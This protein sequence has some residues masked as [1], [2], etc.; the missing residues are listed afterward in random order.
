ME[1]TEKNLKTY[2]FSV[3]GMHCK[4]CILLTEGELQEHPKVVSA[5]SDLGE[6][7]VTVQGDFGLMS[8]ETLVSELNQLL[9]KHGY[10]LSI[11]QTQEKRNFSD[12]RLALPLAF[13]LIGLLI[14]LQK[15]GLVELL[16]TTQ[17]I[18]YGTAFLI[19]IVASL[20]SCLAIVGGLAL[21]VSASF[22]KGGDVVKPQLLFHA[23]RLIAFFFLGGMIGAF[24]S[25]FI[26]GT[27]GTFILSVFTGVIMLLLGLNLLD[28]FSWTKSVQLGMPKRIGEFVYRLKRVNHR[29]TPFLL[30]GA[31]FFMP[32]GFTQSMQIYT[33]S[34]GSFLAGALTMTAFAL[35]TLPVL[36]LLSFGPLG[37]RSSPYMGVFFKTA[38]LIV[39][40][41]ALLALYGSLVAVGVLSPMLNL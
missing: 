33:L 17:E 25:H 36:A 11:D 2:V 9:E 23:G 7:L 6:R 24:G 8:Q 4:A 14:L 32:C 22:A 10:R 12:F 28:I 3:T 15:N 27:T 19:G 18:S 1:H 41:F 38:G 37:V 29:L 21:S 30:G 5:K 40:A 26:L 16:D 13:L 34:A 39:V 35:G 20:S 31:T